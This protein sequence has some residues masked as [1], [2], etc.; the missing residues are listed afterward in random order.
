[1]ACIQH[2]VEN[3]MHGKHVLCFFIISEMCGV[4]IASDWVGVES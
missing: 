4:H 2:V 3:N 1:M